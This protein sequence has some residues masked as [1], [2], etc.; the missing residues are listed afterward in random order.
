MTFK[1]T[2]FTFWIYLIISGCSLKS[3]WWT[4]FYL[5]IFIQ[6]YT[7]S[8]AQRL[9]SNFILD[10]F[11]QLKFFDQLLIFQYFLSNVALIFFDPIN[12]LL[13]SFLNDAFPW[14]IWFAFDF[15]IE[16]RVFLNLYLMTINNRIIIKILI[17]AFSYAG[18]YNKTIS[19]IL[20][21]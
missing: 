14:I 1:L 2:K 15:Y 7:N 20:D 16:V 17:N 13:M 3:I 18:L 21:E 8:C 10:S 9:V 11:N 5:A 6:I 12:F 19:Q 4:N